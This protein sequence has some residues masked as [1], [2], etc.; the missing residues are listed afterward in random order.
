[1]NSEVAVALNLDLLGATALIV[2]DSCALSRA[3][4]FL[5]ANTSV[6]HIV[7]E[8]DIRILVDGEVHLCNGEILV[9]ASD[10]GAAG[11]VLSG[12]SDNRFTSKLSSSSQATSAVADVE[13]VLAIEAREVESVE[14]SHF[15]G[16]HSAPVIASSLITRALIV[17]VFWGGK[18][19]GIV[20]V[21][22]CHSLL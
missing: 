5:L 18:S 9:S 20:P 17:G 6:W 16:R 22:S 1:M 11:I 3:S 10:L 19:L 14:A 15:P 2:L 8:V 7:L 13:G 21:I 12:L 4:N